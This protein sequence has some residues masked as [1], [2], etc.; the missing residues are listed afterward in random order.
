MNKLIEYA[1]PTDG[2]QV[3]N[4]LDSDEKAI[5][6]K[7]IDILSFERSKFLSDEW[8]LCPLC[9]KVDKSN[10]TPPTCKYASTDGNVDGVAYCKFSGIPPRSEYE[11]DN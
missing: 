6:G 10:Q 1:R 4:V 8:D 5:L 3:S 2:S 9:V 11:V 7:M